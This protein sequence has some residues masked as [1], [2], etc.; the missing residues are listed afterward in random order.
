M[1]PLF[2]LDF[3]LKQA[4]VLSCVA[5]KDSDSGAGCMAA[6]KSGTRCLRKR[7]TG[8]YCQQHYRELAHDGVKHL[9][10]DMQDMFDAARQSWDQQQID[11]ALKLSHSPRVIGAGSSASSIS[12]PGRSSLEARILEAHSCHGCWRLPIYCGC[13]VC[14]DCHGPFRPA[15]GGRLVLEDIS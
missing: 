12:A 1:Q 11:L 7:V 6:T 15:A 2:C 14:W 10:E 9:F 4:H 13:L 5:A 3:H 8:N